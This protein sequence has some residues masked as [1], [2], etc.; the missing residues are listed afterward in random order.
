MHTRPHSTAAISCAITC[1]LIGG[2]TT[3]PAVAQPAFRA[4]WADAFHA[5][6]KG[7]A[8]IDTMISMAVAGNYN[9]VIPE[10]L[11]YHD[12]VGSGHG[13]YWNSSIVPKAH[14]IVG[15][16]DPLEYMVTQAHANGLEV[17]PW[18]VAFRVS[19]S[20]P[21]AGNAI[22]TAHPEWLMVPRGDIGGGPAPVDGKYTL[23]PGSP[24][25]QE[26]LMSIVRE[27][28]TNYEVDGIHW[29]YIRYTTTNAG[30]PADES[31]TRSGLARF[32]EIT[33][34]SGVPDTDYGPWSDFRRRGVT[35]VVR[36][37]QAE[38][39]T[40]TSN[41]RQ[42]LR[43]TAS[44]ITWGDAPSNFESTSAWARFQNWREWLDVGY[45]GSIPKEPAIAKAT[46]TDM[47]LLLHEPD[48]PASQCLIGIADR[49]HRRLDSESKKGAGFSAFFQ[50]QMG[51]P[52]AAPI[53]PKA[54][55]KDTE[56]KDELRALATASRYARILGPGNF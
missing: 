31:Y 38:M 13:A 34:Y 28:V 36:R 54:D 22:L 52:A 14:D 55:G 25:A 49:L 9:A 41:P 10:V 24:D 56:A 47:P 12:N 33:G 18:L 27:L 51:E 50:K 21:P 29:D 32:A 53:R 6:Y 1:C 26:Y 30:Y 42:P 23:D 3:R 15:D 8:Q 5:G 39:A 37:A 11:A 7:T 35:E 4:F 17:H 16:F 40:I 19:T 43:H 2:F 45:L 44:L 46:R 20:W 48:S